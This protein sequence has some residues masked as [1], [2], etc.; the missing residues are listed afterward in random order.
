MA[1]A[2]HSDRKASHKNFASKNTMNSPGGGGN[3]NRDHTG[4]PAADP[5]R[6]IGQYGDAGQPPLMKK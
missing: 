5:K 6:R 2:K 3:Q 4:P 1:K